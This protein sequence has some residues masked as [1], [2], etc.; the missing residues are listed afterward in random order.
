MTKFNVGDVVV[1][2]KIENAFG[3]E[4]RSA[5]M[6]MTVR[7]RSIETPGEQ[8]VYDYGVEDLEGDWISNVYEKNLTPALGQVEKQTIV[9][10]GVKTGLLV[11]HTTNT[12][13]QKV[14]IQRIGTKIGTIKFDEIDELI[15]LLTKLKEEV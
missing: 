3:E 1:L 7:I 6:P 12:K 4:T 2:N 9:R 8:K 15:G 14:S 5:E 13:K 11:Q 10:V